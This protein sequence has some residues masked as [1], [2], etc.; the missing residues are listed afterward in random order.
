MIVDASAPAA[1]AAVA[2][3]AAAPADDGGDGAAAAAAADD[4][5]DA[6][7][8]ELAAG[9][10]RVYESAPR[11]ALVLLVVQ[12]G[13]PA[14]VAQ[15][16]KQRALCRNPMTASVWRPEHAAA[17]RAAQDGAARGALFAKIK[18]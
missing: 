3:R 6:A 17:L 5:V 12:H 9:L 8:T 14:R 10:G 2:A 4:A 18:Q 13:E 7:A 16:E 15:L 1:P 11:G